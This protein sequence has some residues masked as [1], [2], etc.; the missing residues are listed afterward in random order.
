[1]MTVYYAFIKNGRVENVNVFAEENQIL[2]DSI[3]ADRGYDSAVYTGETI[4]PKYGAY[5]GTTFF[6][7]S[8]EYLISI[9]I[10]QPPAE[11]APAP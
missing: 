2:A 8:E 6:E 3:V 9:G 7:P 11:E 10:M 5:D 1:M 4:V